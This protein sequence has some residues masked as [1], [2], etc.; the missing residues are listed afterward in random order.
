ML[1]GALFFKLYLLDYHLLVLRVVKIN[2]IN[3]NTFM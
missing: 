1:K 3:I 2:K